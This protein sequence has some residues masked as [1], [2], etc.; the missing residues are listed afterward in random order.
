MQQPQTTTSRLVSCQ[1]L[2]DWLY[3]LEFASQCLQDVREGQEAT[4]PLG[5]AIDALIGQIGKTLEASQ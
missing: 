4:Q 5:F 3:E 1:A 2:E